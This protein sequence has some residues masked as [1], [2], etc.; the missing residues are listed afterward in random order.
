MRRRRVVAWRFAMFLLAAAGALAFAGESPPAGGDVILFTSDDAGDGSREIHAVTPLGNAR[1][2]L[3]RHSP[4]GANPAWSPNGRRI[5]F[6]A[7]ELDD[8]IDSWA[9]GDTVAIWTI[10]PKGRRPARVLTVDDPEK[11]AWS[12]DGTRLAVTSEGDLVVVRADGLNARR[13]SSKN[14]DVLDF[15]WAPDGRRLAVAEWRG[16]RLGGGISIINADGGPFRRITRRQ[17]R[18]EIAAEFFMI[19]PVW[20]PNGRKVAFLRAAGAYGDDEYLLNLVVAETARKHEALIARGQIYDAR[21]APNGQRLALI[22]PDGIDTVRSN[23]TGRRKV[24]NPPGDEFALAWTRDGAAILT[25]TTNRSGS[26]LY[27]AREGRRGFRHLAGTRTTRSRLFYSDQQWAPNGRTL[28]F[29]HEGNKYREPLAYLELLRPDGRRARLLHPAI[30]GPPAWSPSGDAFVFDRMVGRSRYTIQVASAR[31][32]LL[33]SLGAGR[34]PRWSPDGRQIAFSRKRSIFVIRANGG[35]A[36][37]VADGFGTAWSPDS[38]S[39]AFIAGGSAWLIDRA[40]GVP[41]LVVEAGRLTQ[42][43][44]SA[45]SALAWAPDGVR[46]AFLASCGGDYDVAGLYVVKSDGSELTQI[47]NGSGYEESLVWSPDGATLAYSD[48]A[49]FVVRPDGTGWRQIASEGNA[50]AWSPDA[51]RI[52]FVRDGGRKGEGNV[53]DHD[54]WVMDANGANAHALT[55]RG[56]NLAPAWRPRRR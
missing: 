48:G 22:T 11:V 32:T 15:A 21:W 56:N 5:A 45:I 14:V 7:S 8:F 31:G 19:S 34:G 44:R 23:R 39:L 42:D 28:V 37:K 25:A 50:L 18:R 3:T 1:T 29:T 9:R 4:Q 36:R 2:R 26:S 43:C 41:R 10:D 6:I 53:L 49:V 40:G 51:R 52:A 38:R 24:G 54:V 30:D 27:I 35:S 16:N 46:L 13:L 55:R 12:P 20:S 17:T 47:R 33:R